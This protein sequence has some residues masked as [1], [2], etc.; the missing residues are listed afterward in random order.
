ME[1][2]RSKIKKFQFFQ[3]LIDKQAKKAY[4]ALD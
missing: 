2:L 1:D 4:R 3:I